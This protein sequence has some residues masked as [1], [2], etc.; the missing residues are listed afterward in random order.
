[1]CKVFTGIKGLA[2]ERKSDDASVI[3]VLSRDLF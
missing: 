2:I 1:M 3:N